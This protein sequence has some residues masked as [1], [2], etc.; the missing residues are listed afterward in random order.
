MKQ[1]TILFFL[2]TI[3]FA[4]CH[5]K[6]EKETNESALVQASAGDDS[7]H[8]ATTTSTSTT[9]NPLQWLPIRHFPITDTTRFENFEKSG[10][11]DKQGFL[12]RIKFDPK[13]KDATNFRLNYRIPFSDSFSSVVIT[14]RAGENELFTTLLTFDKKD[15]IIDEL[16]IA[17]DE[18]AE[19]AF[20]KTSKIEKDKITIT[21]SNWMSEEPISEKEIYMV[22]SNGKFSKVQTKGIQ[23]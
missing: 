23:E 18:V 5:N 8:T 22:E 2:A 15:R 4:A 14:Y 17:Y 16:V 9:A 1:L 12:K 11:T 7:L 19:S 13:R 6:T 3:L 20:S 21:H 10:I